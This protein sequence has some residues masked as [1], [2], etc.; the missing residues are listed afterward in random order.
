MMMT[1]IVLKPREK[2]IKIVDFGF[3]KDQV[4][5]V[6]ELFLSLFC[7]EEDR[8]R[9]FLD[10]SLFLYTQHIVFYISASHLTLCYSIFRKGHF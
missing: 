10:F 8:I 4:L 7:A 5:P 9:M 3:C 2:W 1:L 6:S